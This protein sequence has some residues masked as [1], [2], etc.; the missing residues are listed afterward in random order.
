[1]DTTEPTLRLAPDG[2]VAVISDVVDDAAM[3]S[4]AV[5]G[6]S[7]DS[8]SNPEQSSGVTHP[9]APAAE[10][11][12]GTMVGRY[13]ILRT[14]GRGGMGVVYLAFDAE[15]ERQVALKL[16]NVPSG[17]STSGTLGGVRARMLREAQAL[18]KL[19]HPNVLPVY[20]VGSH[21]DIV[22]MATEY[23]E[24][25]T[26]R[27]WATTKPRAWRDI[28]QVFLAAGRGLAAAHA[29]GLVHR[30]FKPQNV[31]IAHDGRVRVMDFGLVRT[32]SEDVV[33][34]VPD[35]N[36]MPSGHLD[37]DT[38]HGAS[39][40][41][42]TPAYMA[43]E[44][45]RMAD[46]D[47][48]A[49]QFGFCV[50][51]YECLY[52]LR[53]FPSTRDDMLQACQSGHLATPT[54]RRT[55]PAWLRKL[56]LRGLSFHP[57]DRWPSMDA[58][59]HV[60]ASHAHK[61]WY[62]A[63]TV[64][65]VVL[66]SLA[67]ATWA[68][69][70][71]QRSQM[72]SGG[73]A[74]M[75]SIW[76]SVQK[77]TA[78]SALMATGVNYAQDSWLRVESLL[79]TYATQ[80]LEAHQEACEATRVHNVQP[81]TI[82][83]L[84]M[85]C[86][87]RRLWELDGLTKTLSRADARVVERA[88]EA[89]SGLP[90]VSGCSDVERLQAQTPP[91]DDEHERARVD[92]LGERLAEAKALGASGK[93]KEGLENTKAILEEA[94]HVGY[95]PLEAEV[96]L[97][98]AKLHA[99][100]WAPAAE[101]AAM[102]AILL[103]ESGKMDELRAE[104]TVLLVEIMGAIQGLPHEAQTW[105]NQ[106]QAIL[107]RLGG[108][109]A[110]EADLLG[111]LAHASHMRGEYRREL[112][113]G[114]RQLTVSERIKQTDGRGDVRVA[115]G[116]FFVAMASRKLGEYHQARTSLERATKLLEENLG[117]RH[118]QLADM[119]LELGRIYLLQGEYLLAHTTMQRAQTIVEVSLGKER[120]VTLHAHVTLHRGRVFLHEGHHER[121]KESF[122]EAVALYLTIFPADHLQIAYA[123]IFLGDAYRRLGMYDQA[124]AALEK[125]V[126]SLEKHVHKLL[127]MYALTGLGTTHLDGGN[128]RAALAPLE[129]ALSIMNSVEEN[130]RPKEWAETRFA[131]G[132]ALWASGQDPQRG[133]EL[134]SR[135][136]NAFVTSGK[137][138]ARDLATA[139][140]WLRQH[141]L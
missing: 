92:A 109:P 65:A 56:L 33:T 70:L 10:L 61:R 99:D 64:P 52:G 111:S 107:D 97:Q 17:G 88:V 76:S 126:E 55:V 79:D 101:E 1:M 133:H 26:L 53:P 130:V 136:R 137:D 54:I 51:L 86:L 132:R 21:A 47:A 41:L 50:A 110:L 6:A 16:M 131:L 4:S 42:G 37:P 60:L 84:R 83:D 27:E 96:W 125:A 5:A 67:M 123:R 89:A 75:D 35:R 141:P 68:P 103:A 114:Q 9:F 140:T 74:R 20:D 73:P 121:A 90:P 120:G 104:A 32:I 115:R 129:R 71:A 46:V 116:L 108:V 57:N 82:M 93:T 12:I 72:C 113:L 134:V 36:D 49:D 81:E 62:W 2:S 124:R 29:A 118:P 138:Q 58:L 128:A 122:E 43:P 100:A 40:F 95:P 80:W 30:D 38:S 63:A 3:R 8:R 7:K 22:F 23:V 139:E 18:A 105:A 106:A 59:L 94:K 127:L 15:L 39:V 119:F 13:I 117:P 85:R 102:Q 48:R 34:A 98:L 31:M 14:V 44:Q 77:H 45:H 11:E 112:E 69:H 87:Q 78:K 28:V 66:A 135:A 24:G 91:P 19:S 25:N